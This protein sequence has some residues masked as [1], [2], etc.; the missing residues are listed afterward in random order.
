MAGAAEVEGLLTPCVA[1]VIVVGAAKVGGLLKPCVALVIVAGAVEVE[2]SLTPFVVV[3][4]VVR[5]TWFFV[6]VVSWLLM[7]LFVKTELS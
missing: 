4:M 1:L 5:V 2:G 7:V 3:V 6:L